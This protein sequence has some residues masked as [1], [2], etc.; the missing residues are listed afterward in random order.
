MKIENTKVFNLYGAIY[1]SR[2]YHQNWKGSDSTQ[3]THCINNIVEYPYIS[4]NDITIGDNDMKHIK[5]LCKKGLRS[6][7]RKF[8]RQIFVTVD[9][10]A[11]LSFW[12]QMDTYTIGV[13]K[14][15]TSTMHNL[16]DKELTQNDFEGTVFNEQLEYLN[17]L[18]NQYLNYIKEDKY[19]YEILNM[20]VDTFRELEAN[21][22]ISYLQMRSWSGNYEVLRSIYEE[23][24]C[25]I[26]H[27]WKVIIDWISNLP[28]ADI[29]IKGV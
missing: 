24:Q 5:R 9:I 2:N 17:Y 16:I 13:S 8:L 21:L 19:N 1:A 4:Y 7:H 22:P 25:H 20:K 10:T 6:S 28:Y 14:Q 12:K 23:R 27:E 26:K 11:S 29:L 15:S 18:I 3:N